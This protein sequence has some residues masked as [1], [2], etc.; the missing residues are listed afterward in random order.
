VVGDGWVLVRDPGEIAVAEVF[1]LFVFDDALAESPQAQ[2]REM[3]ARLSAR[4][5]VD[6]AT[7]LREL[8]AE[9]HGA[10]GAAAPGG[11]TPAGIR[12]EAAG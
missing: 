5:E 1:R 7:T 12:R 6:L 2:V 4:I 3:L 10:G 11:V 9:R 8:S